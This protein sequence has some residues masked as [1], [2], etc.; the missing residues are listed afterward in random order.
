MVILQMAAMPSSCGQC[1][2]CM[3]VK[4]TCAYCMATGKQVKYS[5]LD[6]RDGMCPL[7]YET[8]RLTTDETKGLLNRC[9]IYTGKGAMCKHCLIKDKCKKLMEG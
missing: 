2:L 4:N 8:E 9:Y 3:Q 1:G 6:M 5:E 7:E